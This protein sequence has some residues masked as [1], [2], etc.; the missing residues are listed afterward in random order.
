MPCSLS[1][2][3]LISSEAP[4]IERVANQIL[5]HY[6]YYRPTLLVGI[7]YFVG[8]EQII[9]LANVLLRIGI[10]VRFRFFQNRY[11]VIVEKI[12]EDSLTVSFIVPS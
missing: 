6:V 11:A 8:I 9:E 12:V 2:F 3:A 7:F 1:F 4:L 5:F 10:Q